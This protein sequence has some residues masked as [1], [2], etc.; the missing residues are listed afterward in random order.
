MNDHTNAW[1]SSD[2]EL[3]DELDDL[4][5]DESPVPDAVA[6][7]TDS[8]TTTQQQGQVPSTPLPEYMDSDIAAELAGEMAPTWL[9]V[10]WRDIPEADQPAAWNGLRAWVD[11][12]VKEYRL[13]T[14]AVPPCWYKHTD[15]VAELYAAMCMEYKVWEEGE[16][17]INPMMF[18]HTNLQQMVARLRDAVTSAG[19]VSGGAHKEPLAV[20]GHEPFELDYD[21]S[22]WNQHVSVASSVERIDRPDDGVLFV[23]AGVVKGNGGSI[24]Y[25]ESVGIKHQPPVHSPTVDIRYFSTNSEYSLVEARWEQPSHEDELIWETSTDGTNWASPE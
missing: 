23:R 4:A 14:T 5:A 17:N 19:C 6:G 20:E 10:R 24:V 1:V 2:E 8:D 22:D 3:L 12:L 9:G 7:E 15:I 25:S 18:W 21:E 11:W 13:P 16:P